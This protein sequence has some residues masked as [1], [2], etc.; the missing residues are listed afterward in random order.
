MLH[1]CFLPYVVL[2]IDWKVQ[3]SR[4]SKDAGEGL[5]YRTDLPT[6]ILVS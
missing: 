1:Y 2:L 5:Q 3:V 4:M 6:L